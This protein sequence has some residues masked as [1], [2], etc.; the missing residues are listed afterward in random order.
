M[1]VGAAGQPGV[2]GDPARVPAHHLDDQDAHVGLGG[3]VQP[4][5]GLG[6]DADRGVEAEGVVG[7]G[8]VVVDGLGHA[9]ALDAVL[10][11]QP[12]GD[13]EGVLA[14]DRDQRVDLVLGEVL[15]DPADTVLRL[16]R[17]GAGR[18]EDG[19][20]A[21]QDAAYG[22]DVERD[23]VALERAAPAVPVADEFV[24]VLLHALA[25]EPRMTALSPGQSPPPVSTPTRMETSLR[26]VSRMTATLMVIQVTTGWDERS[27]PVRQRRVDAR[28]SPVRVS[29]GRGP[30]DYVVVE[31][32]LDGVPHEL[33]AVVQLELAERVLDVVLDSAVGDDQTLGDLLVRE[34]LGDQPQHLG[35]ALGELRRLRLVARRRGRGLGGEPAVLAE[36]QAG[37]AR[38]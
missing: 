34:P 14:A 21:G 26:L 8:Q 1:T 9:D 15:L 25:D 4:V 37:E 35:L 11:V 20:A 2:Q 17:V 6:G 23:G 19:A 24:R 13:A 18:A 5:D 29:Y 12:R 31:A 33:H 38:A 36:H 22:R 7:G 16:E 32:P 27:I 28:F 3:G 10:V 30:A